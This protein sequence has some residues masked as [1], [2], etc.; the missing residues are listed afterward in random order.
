MR[1]N[2]V[3]K[4]IQNFVD[5]NNLTWYFRICRKDERYFEVDMNKGSFYREVFE[6][7]AE[8]LSE[9]DCLFR[10]INRI[11]KEYDYIYMPGEDARL[12]FASLDDVDIKRKQKKKRLTL[13]SIN[14][15]EEDV[16]S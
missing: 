5:E 16:L 9:K 3:I 7:G 10:Q 12:Y 1:H 2:L 6:K 13:T 15:N 4:A 14:Y 8:D 11:L